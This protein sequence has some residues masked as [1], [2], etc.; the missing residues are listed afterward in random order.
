MADAY[1]FTGKWCKVGGLQALSQLK[2]IAASH[3]AE[4]E[5]KWLTQTGWP[6]PESKLVTPHPNPLVRYKPED[7]G[8]SGAHPMPT[9]VQGDE[10]EEGVFELTLVEDLPDEL[11]TRLAPG[12]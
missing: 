5:T 4:W 12:A 3:G 8:G 1:L 9:Y 6:E 2:E 10:L 7:F 11:R